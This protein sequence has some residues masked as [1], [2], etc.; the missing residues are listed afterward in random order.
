MSLS[1][2]AALTM[3]DQL[4]EVAWRRVFINKLASC[5]IGLFES[6]PCLEDL[7]C[8]GYGNEA[9][10]CIEQMC[11]EHLD[12]TG[13]ITQH[14][15]CLCGEKIGDCP[16]FGSSYFDKKLDTTSPDEVIASINALS[17]GQELFLFLDNLETC[18]VRKARDHDD[19]QFPI[20]ENNL[21]M[22]SQSFVGL[23]YY[24]GKGYWV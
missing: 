21:I 19:G 20:T 11:E 15:W 5:Y 14:A 8:T 24:Q 12:T 13:I 6:K 3:Y 17:V 9:L 4:W 1:A 7:P 22:W 16:K 2:V 18:I 23:A 10:A